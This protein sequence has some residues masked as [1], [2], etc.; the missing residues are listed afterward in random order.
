MLVASM[1]GIF[2]DVLLIIVC[3]DSLCR[4]FM[5]GLLNFILHYLII[6]EIGCPKQAQHYLLYIIS[7]SI[8]FLIHNLIEICTYILENG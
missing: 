7:I 5:Q 3:V 2:A 8:L 4:K 6:Y 1:G